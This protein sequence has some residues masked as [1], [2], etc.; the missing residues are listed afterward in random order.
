MCTEYKP[1]DGI[2]TYEKYGLD[3]LKNFRDMPMLNHKQEYGFL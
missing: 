2:I 1:K 3:T